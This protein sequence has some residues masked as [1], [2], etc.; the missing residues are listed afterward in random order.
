M[1]SLFIQ[2]SN[3]QIACQSSVPGGSDLARAYGLGPEDRQ[4]LEA[5][6][7]DYIAVGQ[8]ILAA[9]AREGGGGRCDPARKV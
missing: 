4:F 6:V 3:E 9:R 2:G 1:Q 8:A 7:R 5:F